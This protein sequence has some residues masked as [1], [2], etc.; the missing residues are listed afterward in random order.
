[1]KNIPISQYLKNTTQQYATI[2]LYIK[3]E[4]KTG[5]KKAKL[6]LNNNLGLLFFMI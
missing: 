3:S 4:N 2:V 1:M 5:K 6:I